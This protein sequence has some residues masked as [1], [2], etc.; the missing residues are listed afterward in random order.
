MWIWVVIDFIWFECLNIDYVIRGFFVD[1]NFVWCWLVDCEVVVFI[2]VEIEGF[3]CGIELVG[4]DEFFYLIMDY[5]WRDVGVIIDCFDV[6]GDEIVIFGF[7]GYFF[8]VIVF[9]VCFLL[10]L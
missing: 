10:K 5:G 3:Y 7:I 4:L 9:F 1:M 8:F 2:F 6:W